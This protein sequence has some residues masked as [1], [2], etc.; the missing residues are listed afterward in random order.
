VSAVST[1]GVQ[2]ATAC[3]RTHARA[4]TSPHWL[5]T[6]GSPRFLRDLIQGLPMISIARGAAL[7]KDHTARFLDKPQ[8]VERSCGALPVPNC[9][10]TTWDKLCC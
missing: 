6:R 8:T 10:A 7:C 9:S 1:T 2:L 5:C 4:F 3:R